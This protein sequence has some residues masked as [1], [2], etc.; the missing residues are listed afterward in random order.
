ME[1]ALLAR[2]AEV[3][4]HTQTLPIFTQDVILSNVQIDIEGVDVIACRLKMTEVGR[5]AAKLKIVLHN[6]QYP[7]DKRQYKR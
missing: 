2:T 6:F 5:G 4:N 7:N 1:P 3:K